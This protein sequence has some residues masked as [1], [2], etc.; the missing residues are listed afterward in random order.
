MAVVALTIRLGWVVLMADRGPRFDEV[1]YL[2][3]AERLAAGEGYVD[4]SG[5][6][7]AYW[8][9]GYPALLS[10]AFRI[11][12]PSIGVAV[13]LQVVLGV[14][15]CLLLS[16]VGSRILSQPAGR[17]AGLL[18]AL[19][20]THVFYS[21]LHLTEPLFGLLLLGAIGC[22]VG[23][24]ASRSPWQ[25]GAGL[26]LGLA[27]LTRPLIV[28]LPL[29]LPLALRSAKRSRRQALV[30]TVVV[31]ASMSA[32]IAPWIWR[33]QELTGR[34][35]TLTT[36]GGYNFWVGNFPQ[37]VGGY[38]RTEDLPLPPEVEPP[39]DWHRGYSWGL[40][41]IRDYPVRSLLRL[42]LKVSHLAAIESDGVL[43]NLKGFERPPPMWVTLP[44]LAVANLV[45]IMVLATATWALI[46]R[47]RSSGIGEW[48][49]LLCGYT[50]LIVMVFFGDPRFHLPLVPFLLLGSAVIMTGEV[51]L[52]RPGVQGSPERSQVRRWAVLMA[53][54]LLLMGINLVVKR[55][56][57]A[58]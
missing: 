14:A 19:Y 6:R 31:A 48:T 15:T 29:L 54:L 2:G 50:V 45:Y 47:F 49:A 17:L 7:V 21:S 57:G 39:L 24:R 13:G 16:I 22:L 30:A 9:V 28:L 8:P 46:S 26:L 25:V 33:N 23:E 5:N 4:P 35:T 41:A 18:L 43:W 51:P 3:L 44:L 12:G 38:V 27:V 56:G 20:P 36:S 58:W 42:P 37:A 10:L 40:E 1:D 55:L 34:W 52:P 32:V 53:G 11:L